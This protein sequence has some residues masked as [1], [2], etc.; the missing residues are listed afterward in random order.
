MKTAMQEMLEWTRKTFSMD[1]L[2]KQT[3]LVEA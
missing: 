1:E 3:E 2:L